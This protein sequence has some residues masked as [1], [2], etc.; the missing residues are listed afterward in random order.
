MHQHLAH[1]ATETQARMLGHRI[2]PFTVYSRF[3][4]SAPIGYGSRRKQHPPLPTR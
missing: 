1:S 2:A 4:R 3:T